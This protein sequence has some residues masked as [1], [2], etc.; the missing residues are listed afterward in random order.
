[1]ENPTQPQMGL[2][3]IEES[4][5]QIGLEQAI[6]RPK[7]P[8]QTPAQA[9][10]DAIASLTMT[11]YA[12][13]ATLALTDTEIAEL[14]ADFPD[15]AFKPGASG[16]EHLIYIEHAFL[17]ER[18][19]K[20][21]RPGQWSIIPRNRWAEPFTTKS[22]TEGSRVYVE[23]M[24]VIRGA[25]VSE[26]I[27]EMEYYPSNAAQNYGDAVEGAKTA[28]LR[29][30]CKELGVGLQSWKKDFQ[31]G[32]WARRNGRPIGQPTHQETPRAR[33]V[34][35]DPRIKRGSEIAQPAKRDPNAPPQDVGD[36]WREYKITFGKM[37]GKALGELDEANIQW[38]CESWTPKPYQGAI[39]ADSKALRTA[40]DLACVELGFSTPPAN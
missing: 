29:R 11:A 4:P 19:N 10:V 2:T 32:W 38:W 18:L 40:L 31:D 21:F 28:A 1:M 22:G 3:K 20:V 27:G 34:P 26:A 5:E 25:F 15:E 33:T 35:S 17:R 6:D 36:E 8:L 16:K 9:K 14:G 23:A 30:C 24:L 37:A 39:S 7:G 12:K 13:A